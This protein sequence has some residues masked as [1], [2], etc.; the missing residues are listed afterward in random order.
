MLVRIFTFFI[1]SFITAACQIS[2][3]PETN[4]QWEELIRSTAKH[5][6]T[7][8]RSDSSSI[9]IMFDGKGSAESSAAL[10]LEEKITLEQITAAFDGNTRVQIRS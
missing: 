2:D 1:I 5:K 9:E 6:L 10:P 4:E 3:C 7:Y 8:A